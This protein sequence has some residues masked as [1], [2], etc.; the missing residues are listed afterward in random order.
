MDVKSADQ[1]NFNFYCIREFDLVIN[2]YS[3]RKL[4]YDVPDINQLR[5]K[6]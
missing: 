4:K 1:N 3:L 2:N 6:I 5:T